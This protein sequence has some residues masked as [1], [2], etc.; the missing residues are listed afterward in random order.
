MSAIKNPLNYVYPDF[1]DKVQELFSL[2]S[3][4]GYPLRITESIRSL[5]RQ[6]KLYAQGR[7]A[8]GPKVTN[9]RPGY[10]YHHYGLAVDVCFLGK[11]P[12]PKSKDCWEMLGK[13]A[14]ELGITWGGD[15]KHLVDKPHL[16]LSYG[17][18]ISMLY[19]LIQSGR[20]YSVWSFIDR[21]RK[22]KTN[23]WGSNL[24]LAEQRLFQ[25]EK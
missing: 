25:K 12:Y 21:K 23:N 24:A 10:S 16:Q 14:N 7:T 20:L 6:E 5:D 22:A 17:I 19:E 11:E 13:Y 9:A 8:P 18:D 4:A 1:A 3:E 15:F 2:M